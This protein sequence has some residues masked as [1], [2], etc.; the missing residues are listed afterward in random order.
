MQADSRTESQGY[1]HSVP[2][3]A[4]PAWHGVCKYQ[5]DMLWHAGGPSQEEQ[6]RATGGAR[7]PS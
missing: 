6:S 7:L 2:S 1:L 4:I 5:Q 3:V